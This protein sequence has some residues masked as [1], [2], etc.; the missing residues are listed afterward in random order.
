MKMTEQTKAPETINLIILQANKDGQ[1]S[2]LNHPIVRQFSS[3]YMLIVAQALKDVA[4]GLKKE[5]QAKA[6]VEAQQA[7]DALS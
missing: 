3:E 6:L 1:L 2:C 5:G 4:K 7:R